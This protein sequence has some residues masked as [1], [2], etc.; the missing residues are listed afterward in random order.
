[1][2]IEQSD[3]NTSEE[4]SYT[5]RFAV[6]VEAALIEFMAPLIRRFA[7]G[8]LGKGKG[9]WR[10]CKELLA[11]RFPDEFSE[12]THVAKSQRIEVGGTIEH[13]FSAMRLQSMSD[14]ELRAE[15]EAIHWSM[16]SSMIY[17]DELGEVIGY[18]ETKLSLM[19]HH[20]A[21]KTAYFPDRETSWRPG[22]KAVSGIEPRIIEHEDKGITVA[23]M[24]TDASPVEVVAP[25]P[26]TGAVDEGALLSV[27]A[28]SST[29]SV[30]FHVDEPR[31]T[32]GI[33]Y[34]QHGLAFR[35][36][37]EETKL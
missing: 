20:H 8:A 34:D 16:R 9:D 29:P 11:S 15:L 14:A 18:M 1:M 26:A 5:A 13:D 37:D 19:R 35:Y 7:D 25:V 10:A 33:G 21:A 30:S 31:P 27:A 6:A 32:S 22:S 2:E 24:A 12:R 3:A 17:G 28:P 23:E 4:L 36:D